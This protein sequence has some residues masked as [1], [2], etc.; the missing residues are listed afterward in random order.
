MV[1]ALNGKPVKGITTEEFVNTARGTIDTQ[2]IMTV[3]RNG[4]PLDITITRGVVQTKAVSSKML[5]AANGTKVGY[6]RLESFIQQ[7]TPKEMYDALGSLKDADR[8][9]LDLRFNPGGDVQVCVQLMSMF[10]ERGTLVSIRERRP[11]AG[12][13]KM[14][15]AADGNNI[16]VIY[17][18]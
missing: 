18:R 16:T 13:A 9:I 4:T 5:T 7:T 12:H 15:Y 6:I 17:G 1:K 3:V 14:T 2:L 10:I 8:I 11:G